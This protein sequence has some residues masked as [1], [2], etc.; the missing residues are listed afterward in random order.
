[1]K[2]FITNIFDLNAQRT[3]IARELTGGATT[4]MTMAYII[5]VQP[6]VL[7]A[8]GMDFGGVMFAT[9]ISAAAGSLLMAFLSNYPIA[10][11]PGMGQ[12]FYFTYTVVLTLG[13]S[14]QQGLGMVFW[15]GLV[16]LLLSFFGFREKIINSIPASLK[17]AIA[18]GIGL[19]I[20]FIGLEWSGIVVDDP[21]L[22][23]G[24]GNFSDPS[25]LLSITGLALTAVLL[26]RNT[27]GAIL[28]GILTTALLGYFSGTIHYNGIF[29][30]PQGISET[31]AQLELNLPLNLEFLT[32]I[33]I[34][35]ILDLFDTVG[36]LVGVASGAGLMK[37]DKLPKARQALFSDASASIIGAVMGTTTVT[38]Y[39]ESASGVSSGARTGLANIMTAALFLMALF[40]TP[41][42]EMIGG[43]VQITENITRYP[44]IAPALILVGTFMF[45]GISKIEWSDYT[46]SIPAFLTIIIIPFSFRITEGIAFG[47]I[48][49]TL[50]K[51]AAGKQ[52][53]IPVLVW[54]FG[55]V[56][57]L[58][59]IFVDLG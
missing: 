22:L 9:C 17:Q 37:E 6:A 47:F 1:M 57:L 26:A 45:K 19:L 58:R 2:T 49:W 40:F 35:L 15:A 12:N 16:F 10:L 7:S 46:E 13:I 18:A 21:A 8:A 44:A 54:V 3:T 30:M 11:A 5:F 43:G 20:T 31:F 52:K 53:E 29:G 39:I 25:T 36:T 50:L 34:F 27:P 55:L 32:I 24:L 56:F 33:F 4:F 28:I 51:L 42:I 48:A 41:L 59:Y 38:S 14:W 23:V